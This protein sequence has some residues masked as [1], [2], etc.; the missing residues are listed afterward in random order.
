MA[1][2]K[3][4]TT[5]DIF[6]AIISRIVR[7]WLEAPCIRTARY[8]L[9]QHL[10]HCYRQAFSA[11]NLGHYTRAH[12]FSEFP[13]SNLT[14]IIQRVTYPVL[15]EIQMMTPALPEFTVNS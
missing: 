15:C 11:S 2:V 14:G 3:V 8:H 7:L 4:E 1:V 5:I 10:S 9:S 13:S 12:Q 6:L